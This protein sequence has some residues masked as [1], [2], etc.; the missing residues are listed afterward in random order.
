ME[1]RG[2]HASDD[3]ETEPDLGGDGPVGPSL[4][5]QLDDPFHHRYLRRVGLDELRIIPAEAE[6]CV[7]TGVVVALQLRRIPGTDVLH[8]AR[9]GA[10]GK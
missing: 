10:K 4:R 7:T 5:R 1:R 6:G 8:V 3:V 9:T 2:Q